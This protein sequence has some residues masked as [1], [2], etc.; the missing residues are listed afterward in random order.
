MTA[1]P[2]LRF[3]LHEHFA[4]HHHFD[5][6]LEHDGVLASWAVPKGLPEKGGERRLAIAVEDHP[7]EYLGFEA[8]IP[9]GEYGAG[10]VKI[11]DSGTYDLLVWDTD[12]IEVVLHGKDYAGKYNLIRFRKS[13]ENGWLIIRSR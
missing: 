7:I 12:R 8:T 1:G 11:R 3:V 2:D 4:R 6:R 10:D 9:E 13:G 5:F